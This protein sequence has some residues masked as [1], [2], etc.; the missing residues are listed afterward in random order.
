MGRHYLSRGKR[1][2]RNNEDYVKATVA[3]NN[4]QVQGIVNNSK[5]LSMVGCREDNDEIWWEDRIQ[6]VI[7]FNSYVMRS[8]NKALE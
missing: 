7:W 4:K 1:D 5:F 8:W 3:K 6:I 2:S